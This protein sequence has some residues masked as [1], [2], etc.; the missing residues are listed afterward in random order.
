MASKIVQVDSVE[1][2][3]DVYCGDCGK[4]LDADFNNKGNLEVDPCRTCIENAVKDARE[5]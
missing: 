4:A 1:C 3:F 2:E 5:D